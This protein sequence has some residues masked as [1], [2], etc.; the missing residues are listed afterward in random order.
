LT[1]E[2]RMPAAKTRIE[3]KID[4][5]SK[6]KNHVIVNT[7][8]MARELHFVFPTVRKVVRFNIYTNFF[9]LPAL[10]WF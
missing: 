6:A 4:A 10:Y 7:S 5:P 9:T 1:R 2:E 3:L 8:T